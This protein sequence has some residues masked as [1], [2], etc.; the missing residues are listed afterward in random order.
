MKKEM[1]KTRMKWWKTVLVII[2]ILSFVIVTFIFHLGKVARYKSS[3]T[4]AT[5]NC[6]IAGEGRCSYV[7][8]EE[9][10][11]EYIERSI[12]PNYSK[13]WFKKKLLEHRNSYSDG[14]YKHSDENTL[15]MIDRSLKVLE[16]ID[17]KGCGNIC[18]ALDILSVF[19]KILFGWVN[20]WISG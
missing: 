9:E 3:R 15:F 18:L 7:R 11:R 14:R 19:K 20:V 4:S 1:N 16:E 6:L 13:K 2:I 10:T 8:S 12:L 17:N 5:I